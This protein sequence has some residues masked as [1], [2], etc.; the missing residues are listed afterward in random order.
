MEARRTRCETY[1]LCRR[2]D[3]HRALLKRWPQLKSATRIGGFEIFPNSTD[4]IPRRLICAAADAIEL[5]SQPLRE[6]HGQVHS[7][8]VA[9][10]VDAR[11]KDR[12]R[13]IQAGASSVMDPGRL[14][15]DLEPLFRDETY[16]R[17]RYPGTADP[18]W[19]LS[20]P[21]LIP[22]ER[23]DLRPLYRWLGTQLD[24]R[25]APL[26]LV[27]STMPLV[28]DEAIANAREHGNASRVTLRVDPRGRGI[29][30]RVRD[31]GHGFD[32]SRLT[33]PA[34]DSVRGRGIPLLR[35]FSD[36]LE[37][38]DRGRSVVMRVEA[39]PTM[40]IA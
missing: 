13:L 27:R 11:L 1:I 24:E 33:P 15:E 26:G 30:I 14:P 36:A 16:L 7:L 40:A 12:A 21:I 3:H 4:P 8:R 37:W 6:L 34:A 29:E 25:G 31:G 23:R 22:R 17:T 5:A 39:P 20:R 18:S 9:I 32:P 35:H 2:D 28:L 10:I 38:E 19:Q